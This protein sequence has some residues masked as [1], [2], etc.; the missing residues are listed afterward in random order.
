MSEIGH[1]TEMNARTG[2]NL[3][4]MDEILQC[5]VSTQKTLMVIKDVS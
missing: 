3:Y 4:G 2:L 1:E 5:I